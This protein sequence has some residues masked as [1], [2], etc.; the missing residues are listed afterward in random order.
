MKANR[1]IGISLSTFGGLLA[2]IYHFKPQTVP[3]STVF[4]A[5]IS[6]VL[7]TGMAVILPRRGWLGKVLNPHAFN[8]K[9]HAAIIVMSSA[10]ANAPLAVD[11]IASQKLF[12][13]KELN[14]ATG[15][16]LM[17][18]SQCLGYGF[19]GLLRRTL[20]YPTK[21]LYPY[22]LP[23]NSLLEALYGE[24]SQVKKKLAVFYVGFLV[25]FF[26]EIIPQWI[27]PAL[28]GVS[29]FC[30][31]KRDSL[32]FTNL[33]GGSNG[34]EGLGILEL[35]F[36][37]QYIS[38]PSPLWYPLQTLFNSFVGYVLCVVVFVAAFYGNLWDA[39]KFPF[40]SQLLFTG[41]SNG[42]NYVQFNQTAILNENMEVDYS[43]LAQQGLPFF[44]TT[45]ALFI[46]ANNLSITATFSH[47]FLWNYDDIKSAWEFMKIENLRKLANPRTWNWKFW[48]AKDDRR[49]G[50]NDPET[51]PHYRLMLAYKDAPDWWYTLTLVISIIVA[52]VVL[53]KSESTLPWWGF[54]VSCALSSVCILFFGAQFAITGYDLNLQPIIQMIGGYLH[55]GKPVANMYFVLFGFNSVTQGELLLRDL[56]FAQ[57]AHLCP[58]ATFV[59]QMV[60]PP[61]PL[62]YSL[63]PLGRHDNRRH[64]L[65]HPHR[66]HHH[67]PAR[68]PAL[69]RGHRDLVRQRRADLQLAGH[70]LG[71]P[72]APTLLRRRPLPVGHVLAA[73]RLPA[74][75]PLLGRAQVLP[76]AAAGLLEH[77]HYC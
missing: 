50:P 56:K 43:L 38:N 53:Y 67:Q 7:G 9:E 29:F 47:L 10:A 41:D 32:L 42:T 6:Y 30:L 68:H 36:D 44:T 48:Q 51:D 74:A 35:S 66:L 69:H 73:D 22:N 11:V 21:M 59:M 45:F 72:C 26:Y 3:V 24:K 12:Y 2:T 40:L 25:L 63:T 57:Y 14:A 5:V 19:A 31:A 61:Y 46:L 4:L 1:V 17:L 76:E 27:M 20:V 34:N 16:L 37:W 55:S 33:F 15:I 49:G 58:R 52:L 75:V 54:L 18:T 28:V 23:I 13:N 71:R 62:R 70:R 65:L 60:Q 8:S 64:I 77:S 39:R